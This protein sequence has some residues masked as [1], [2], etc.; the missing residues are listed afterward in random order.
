MFIEGYTNS[1]LSSQDINTLINFKIEYSQ[2]YVK[3]NSQLVNTL[4]ENLYNHMGQM[5]YYLTTGV[6]DDSSRPD[7]N[8]ALGCL[9]NVNT[10]IKNIFQ[11]TLTL[12]DSNITN[13][14]RVVNKI[15]SKI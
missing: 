4:Y 2:F 15:L 13:M 9:R 14:L 10:E 7:Y 5:S 8:N 6:L 3:Y 11:S 12:S 1:I